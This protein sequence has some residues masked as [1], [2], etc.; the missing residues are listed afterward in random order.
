MLL[1]ITFKKRRQHKCPLTGEWMNTGRHIHTMEHMRPRK[2]MKSWSMLQHG[3]NLK[4]CSYRKKPDPNKAYCRIPFVWHIQNIPGHKTKSSL[5]TAKAGE[6]KECWT[7]E[8][9]KKKHLSISFGSDENI[10]I[11][12]L[13][14]DDGT[15]SWD[16]TTCTVLHLKRVTFW[17]ANYISTKLFS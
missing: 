12:E 7:P 6:R 2:E 1:F 11:L 16:F 17:Y 5:A 9:K 4:T 14:N 15:E 8:K 13:E 3:W 10:N